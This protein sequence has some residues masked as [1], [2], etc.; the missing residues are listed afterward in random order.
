MLGEGSIFGGHW[1]KRFGGEILYVNS[2]V[3]VL[4]YLSSNECMIKLSSDQE[5][6]CINIY[7]LLLSHT[8]N[9]ERH[10]N[11][12]SLPLVCFEHVRVGTVSL[13][14]NSQVCLLKMCTP[15]LQFRF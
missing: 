10:A 15:T 14:V 4:A 8:D 1:W 12:S 2:L 7:S 13:S 5:V 3:P 9:K 6:G 11:K